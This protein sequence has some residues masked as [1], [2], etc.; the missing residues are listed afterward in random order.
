MRRK[1][2]RLR[3]LAGFLLPTVL[4]LLVAEL[5]LRATGVAPSAQFNF[6]LPADSGGLYPVNTR[7]DNVWGYIHYR[8]ETNELGLR[9][10]ATPRQGRDETSRIV[11]IGD[12]VTDGFFVDND[13]TYQHFLQRALDREF[14]PHIRVLNAARGGGSI[15]EELAVLRAIGVPLD[16]DVVVLT[17]VTNDIA[18]L[19]DRSVD[20]LHAVPVP[21]DAAATTLGKHVLATLFHRTAVGELVFRFYWNTFIKK[22]DLEMARGGD[23]DERY[24]IPGGDDFARNV[25]VFRRRHAANTDGKIL[26]ATFSPEIQERVDTYTDVLR[27]FA[28]TCH[29]R[30]IAPVFVYFPSYLEVYEHSTP[31]TIRRHF[32]RVCEEMS[33]RFLDL[34]ETFRREGEGRVLHLAPLDYHLNPAGNEVLGNALFEFL[35]DQ[36]LVGEQ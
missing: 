21:F 30:D 32:A 17:F 36:K 4:V 24:R 29:E 28:S 5:V 11:T 19:R 25:A 27:T 3:R 20:E 10:T 6:L 7:M 23:T 26:T 9:G 8:V 35:R 22:H 13:G 1:R 31:D 15:G 16:P 2:S 14:G 33:M 18:D 12:S 34:T